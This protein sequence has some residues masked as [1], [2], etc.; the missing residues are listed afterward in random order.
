MN[1]KMKKLKV[2]INQYDPIELLEG[3][4]PEDEYE[5]EALEIL[6]LIRRNISLE[7]F[8]DKVKKIFVRSFSID[9][10][11]DLSY[12]DKMSKD[13]FNTMVN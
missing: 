5:P 2:I 10:K 9:P 4:V 1:D 8:Q 12:L 7:D 13:I 3:G 6:E 11:Y